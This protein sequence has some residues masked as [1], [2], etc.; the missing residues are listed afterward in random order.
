[1]PGR[2]IL[3][4]GSAPDFGDDDGAADP[5]LEGALSRAAGPN[6][7]AVISAALLDA[8]VLIPIVAAPTSGEH[9]A[10]MALV[11]M[12]GRDGR[13]ALPAFTSLDALA[14]WRAQARPVPIPARRAAAAA[15]DEEAVALVLDVA[16]PIPHTV[17][18]SRLAA[19]ADG[20]SWQPAHV[21]EQVTATVRGHL[22]ALAGA[23]VSAYVRPSEHADAVV[24]LV[25]PADS[26]PV[27]VESTAREL[28]ARLAAD[29]MLRAR[30]DT[31]LDI[32]IAPS[33]EQFL[34][35]G[36]DQPR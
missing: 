15:Y 1:V 33:A 29:P 19:L 31:G 11:T 30:L 4:P 27:Q 13:R 16:G 20:R 5:L 17:S 18:G 2:T 21:D 9:G 32:A 26:D 25:T 23:S 35:R 24:L 3:E 28:A 10:E 22:L 34:Q 14:R 7:A 12:I 8:R 36:V 6:G